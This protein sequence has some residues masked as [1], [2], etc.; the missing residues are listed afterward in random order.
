MVNKYENDFI[1]D[2]F[3]SEFLNDLFPVL[4]NTQS[5]TQP[6]EM[7][8]SSYDDVVISMPNSPDNFSFYSQNTQPNEMI[9]TSNDS[10]LD[11]PEG[12]FPAFPKGFLSESLKTSSLDNTYTGNFSNNSDYSFKDSQKKQDLKLSR[13]LINKIQQISK[14]ISTMWVNQGT[15]ITFDKDFRVKLY[16]LCGEIKKEVPGL[17]TFGCIDLLK[18]HAQQPEHK[19]HILELR[20]TLFILVNQTMSEMKDQE[21][22]S[23]TDQSKQ[24]DID[25]SLLRLVNFVNR[26]YS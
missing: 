14:Q 8:N 25:F 17:L 1:S 5:N 9:N 6:N 19:R 21:Y 26:K 7:I 16:D 2:E 20:D 10:E 23:L 18:E 4:N 13:S 3:M 24:E 11:F 22:L 15:R 12:F